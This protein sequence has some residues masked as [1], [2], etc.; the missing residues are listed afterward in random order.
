MSKMLFLKL[1]YD[2][3]LPW[4][5][6]CFTDRPQCSFNFVNVDLADWN[7]DGARSVGHVKKN[8]GSRRSPVSP[9]IPNNQPLAWCAGAF[10][11]VC[12]FEW[13]ELGHKDKD[14]KELESVLRQNEC[15]KL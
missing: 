15:V 8:K 14:M 9:T 6:I 7:T 4:R 5:L 12:L 3:E 10:M 1:I 13:A 11:G 2:A